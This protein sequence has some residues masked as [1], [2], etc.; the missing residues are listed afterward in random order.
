[1][2]WIQRKKVVP[3]Q[4]CLSLVNEENRVLVKLPLIRS[5]LHVRTGEQPDKDL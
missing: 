1:M 2:R 3:E 5:E 4:V